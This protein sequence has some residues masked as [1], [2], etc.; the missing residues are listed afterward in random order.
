MLK[1]KQ[2]F[3]GIS[4]NKDF[5]HFMRALASKFVSTLITYPIQVIQTMQRAGVHSE[6]QPNVTRK[7]SWV[8][9]VRRLYRGLESKLIQ[10]CM[11]SALMFLVYKRLVTIMLTLWKGRLNS[12]SVV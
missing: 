10:T 11:N 5:E 9:R 4:G 2:F 8:A 7:G 6:P 1:R 12:Q 3:M